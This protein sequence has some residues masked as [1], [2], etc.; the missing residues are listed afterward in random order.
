ME[1]TSHKIDSYTVHIYASDLKGR[2]TRWGDKVIRL[3][4]GGQ[5][6]AQAVFAIE[7][8]KIPEPYYSDGKIYYFA[9]SSQFASVLS[10]LR[11]SDPVYIAWEPIHDPK[12]PN[13]G[14]A[15]FFTDLVQ[16]DE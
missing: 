4:S 10:L 8:S 1:V 14:D 15:Y 6:V 7:G 16:R 3:Y 11:N 5:E 2:R 13:D 12:E 9:P